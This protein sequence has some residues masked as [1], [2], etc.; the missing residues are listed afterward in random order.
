MKITSYTKDEHENDG[1][2]YFSNGAR[3][4]HIFA[5]DKLPHSIRMAFFEGS[6]SSEELKE[7]ARQLE[8]M[9]Y[10]RGLFP[11]AIFEMIQDECLEYIIWISDAQLITL[12]S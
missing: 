8:A 9:A 11:K 12:I 4:D 3:L 2:F 7:D 5:Y 1:S 10:I 6:P